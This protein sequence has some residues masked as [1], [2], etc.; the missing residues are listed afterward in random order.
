[1][2]ELFYQL[3]IINAHNWIDRLINKFSL[4]AHTHYKKK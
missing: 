1:M 4:S 3:H 2:L